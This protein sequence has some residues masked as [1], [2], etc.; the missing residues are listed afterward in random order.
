[1]VPSSVHQPPLVYIKFQGII[2]EMEKDSSFIK[3]AHSARKSMQRKKF[4]QFM[5][6]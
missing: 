6:F 2:L 1:M 5:L 4:H 3:P